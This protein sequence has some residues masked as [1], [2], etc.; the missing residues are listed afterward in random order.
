MSEEDPFD[1]EQVP[2]AL[3]AYKKQLDSLKEDIEVLILFSKSISYRAGQRLRR[4][5]SRCPS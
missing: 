5:I 1:L 4:R 3:E 2:D